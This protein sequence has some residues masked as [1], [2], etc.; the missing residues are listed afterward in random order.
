MKN[1][2]R[3][4]SAVGATSPKLSRTQRLLHALR[5]RWGKTALLGGSFLL[6][7]GI[8]AHVYRTRTHPAPSIVAT[9]YHRNVEDGRIAA[10][11]LRETMQKEKV[12]VIAFE[13]KMSTEEKNREV[14]LAFEEIRAVFE[15]WRLQTHPTEDA[16]R[17]FAEAL[18]L[19]P[20]KNNPFTPIFAE[21]LIY[22]IPIR[23]VESLSPEQSRRL[24]A[25]AA[26]RDRY[27]TQISMAPTLREAHSLLMKVIQIDD[28]LLAARNADM[29]EE[30]G[31]IKK[32]FRGKGTVFSVVG[33]GHFEV[34]NQSGS[35]EIE[36]FERGQVY[37]PDIKTK[38]SVSKEVWAARYLVIGY[39]EYYAVAFPSRRNSFKGAYERALHLTLPEFRELEKITNGLE[40]PRR[41]EIIINTLIRWAEERR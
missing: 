37:E 19:K 23:F 7:S 33:Q 16:A 20:L 38:R 34:S 28:E 3:G 24:N 39:I 13:K 40:P 8:G 11:K 4:I 6:A 31:K 26:E 9:V 18:L 30:L 32:E 12:A 22:R 21:A 17:K 36:A 25:M 15:K 1:R 5:T 2:R 27:E 10:Q 14:Q 29:V 35:T 41:Q